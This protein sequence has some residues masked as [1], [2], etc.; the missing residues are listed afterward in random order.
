MSWKAHDTS[1]AAATNAS[2]T[3]KPSRTCM[4]KPACWTRRAFSGS[5]AVNLLTVWIVPV[6]STLFTGETSELMKL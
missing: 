2:A 1:G 3:S 4:R 5:A 6:T